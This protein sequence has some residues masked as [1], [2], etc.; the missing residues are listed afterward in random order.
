MGTKTSRQQ[1]ND[2]INTDDYSILNHRIHHAHYDVR[3]S[4]QEP[5]NLQ[6]S[7]DFMSSSASRLSVQ[8]ENAFKPSIFNRSARK[9]PRYI[10][11]TQKVPL[12]LRKSQSTENFNNASN[13]LSMQREKAFTPS[14]F[15]RSVRKIPRYDS[16]KEKVPLGLRKSRS[17]GNLN[18]LPPVMTAQQLFHVHAKQKQRNKSTSSQMSSQS[19]QISTQSSQN[20]SFDQSG[21]IK[22][23]KPKSKQIPPDLK[24]V[25]I[26]PNDLQ[27]NYCDFM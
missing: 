2:R 11:T 17:T 12:G 23:V 9:I 25:V 1:Q 20:Q 27:V 18:D 6:G 22:S 10:P 21:S 7:N 15:N 16:N 3:S 13:R 24:F 19:S 4:I 8:Q 14:L 5:Q 26:N